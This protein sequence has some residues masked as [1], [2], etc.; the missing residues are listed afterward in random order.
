MTD[1]EA[2]EQWFSAESARLGGEPPDFEVDVETGF[3]ID[4]AA[5]LQLDAWLA[6]L[7][8]DRRAA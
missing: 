2:F 1:R 5:Q 3:Y 6:A 4:W 8:W 7:Q